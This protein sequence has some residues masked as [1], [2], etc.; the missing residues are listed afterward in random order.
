MF[1][2]F[3]RRVYDVVLYVYS[4]SFYHLYIYCVPL[5]IHY[6]TILYIIALLLCILKLCASKRRL[7]FKYVMSSNHAVT[8]FIA[9]FDTFKI[10]FISPA[11]TVLELFTGL[12]FFIVIITHSVDV[13]S[14][15]IFVHATYF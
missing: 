1:I 6:S 10:I 7:F 5:H 15:F 9:F 8:H 3:V 2:N 14:S 13:T 4:E 11:S 12:Q